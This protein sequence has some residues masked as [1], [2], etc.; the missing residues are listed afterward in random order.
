MSLLTK[1]LKQTCTYEQQKRDENGN[2][3]L[4]KFGEPSYEAPVT[5]KCR[6]ETLIQ[7]VLTNTGSILKSS[8]RYFTDN[9]HE[10]KAN[11]RLDGKPVLKVQEYINQF[12][13]AE[14]FES[15]A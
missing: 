9:N 6:R 15:Y 11:D 7:D 12:G 5:I 2:A 13:K 14:G 8:T 3:I 1:Y 10:I 4:D